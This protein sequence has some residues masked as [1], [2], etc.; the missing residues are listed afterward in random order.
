MPNKTY[1]LP[2]VIAALFLL[3][4]FCLYGSAGH[5][6]S[7][8]TFWA[9]YTLK[10]FG[11][12]VNYNGDRIEQSSSLLL[13]LLTALLASILRNDVVT[14]G[15]LLTMLAGAAALVM[16]WRLTTKQSQANMAFVAT[17]ILATSPAFLLW[18]T[19]GMESTLTALCLLWFITQWAELLSS[20]STPSA[21][22]VACV[23]FAS[24]CLISVRPEMITLVAA[25]AFALFLYRKIYH[26]GSSVQTVVFYST[27]LLCICLLLGFRYAYFGSLMPLP[28]SAKVSSLGTE[29]LWYGSLY[30]LRYGIANITFLVSLPIA[31]V[32]LYSQKK[33]SK[34]DY[35]LLLSVFALLGYSGFILLSGGDWMQMGRFLVPVLPLAAFLCAVHFQ[36][37]TQRKWFGLVMIAAILMLNIYSNYNTLKLESHG[38]PLWASYRISPQHQQQY[39]IFEQYNQEHVRDMDAID[40]L[41]Q[42]L[43]A[44]INKNHQ[45]ITVMSGQSGMVFFYTAKK[46]FKTGDNNPVHFYDSRSLIEDSLLKC[47]LLDDVPRSSQG[48]YFDFDGFFARQ[49]ALTNDC[50]IPRPDILYDINDMSRQLP[51]RMS[52]Q[53][54]TLIHK[55]GGK[56]VDN[57]STL[58]AN[59]LPAVNFVMVKNDLLADL[60]NTELKII[61]YHEK[62]LVSRLGGSR[63]VPTR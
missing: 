63:S 51:E 45:T 37:T 5:D 47:A 8:I 52:A 57:K 38:T 13:T 32:F 18:N 42:T 39:S 30:L 21:G 27:L 17:I 22:L 55:E 16:T 48:L 19:S 59:T 58:P 11:E 62:P 26:L 20:D 50:G 36:G 24:L 12:I 31:L 3:A 33:N 9:S 49:P 15:Y 41:D 14:T 56:M 43:D 25:M 53:G 2:L 46:Y 4:G 23:F 29:K 61:R 34:P 6:D 60:K 35:Y 54:Y 40:T 28:V 7:H 1:S 10:E 44:L